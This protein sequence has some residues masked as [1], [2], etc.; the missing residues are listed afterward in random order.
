M[1]ANISAGV[2]KYTEIFTVSTK[3]NPL[4]AS[5]F[6]NYPNPFSGSTRISYELPGNGAVTLKVYDALGNL[7]A[8]PVNEKQTAGLHY[9]DFDAKGLNSGVYTYRLSFNDQ[10]I[11]NKM[12]MV[13]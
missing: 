2:N 5:E 7:K 3:E 10:V 6:S 11:S 4:A 8:T 13:K 9:V 1:L 12:L